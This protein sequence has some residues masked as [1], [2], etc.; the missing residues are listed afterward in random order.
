M[1]QMY[2]YK[3][4]AWTLALPI[5]AIVGLFCANGTQC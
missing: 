3:K 4:H 5:N 1:E 2:M